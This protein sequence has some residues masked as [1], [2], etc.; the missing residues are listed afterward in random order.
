MACLAALALSSEA[1]AITFTNSQL[2]VTA[3]AVTDGPVGFA[4]Q[5]SPP[6]SAP[7][8]ASADSTGTTDVATAGAIAAAGLLTTSA[9]VS[10]GG[11]IT[12]SAATA[13]LLASFQ[14]SVAE[15]NLYIAFNPVDFA[16]GSGNV[17][18]SL[19]VAVTR[20]GVTLFQDVASGPWVFSSYFAPGTTSLLDLT[21][22]SE[23]TGGFPTQG[24]GNASSFG[25]VTITSAVPLPAP[26][27]LLLAGLG[28]V[29]AAKRR[30][31]FA[32]GGAR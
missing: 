17:S 32:S 9:D 24:M 26:W 6:S 30:A 27:L 25:Q 8:L 20:G 1:G 23:A 21:L 28:P 16:V 3:I 4:S 14:T 22:T 2:D 11:G 10:A 12:N 5:S 7:V 19:F 18:T 13:H 31:S 15:P 29:A